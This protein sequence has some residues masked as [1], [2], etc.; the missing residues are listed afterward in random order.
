MWIRLGVSISTLD[1]SH[2]IGIELYH[3]IGIELYKIRMV[4][5]GVKSI[6]LVISRG[7]SLVVR[8]DQV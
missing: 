4:P 5:I 3:L 8:K 7:T 6:V 2:L 1:R